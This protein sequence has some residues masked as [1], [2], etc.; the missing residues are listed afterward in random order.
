[1]DLLTS[2][3]ACLGRRLRDGS[4]SAVE[5]TEAAL[6]RIVEWDDVLHAFTN[7]MSVRALAQAK[8]ADAN[9][10][11]GIDLGPLQGI[12]YGVKDIFDVVGE[13][14]TCQSRLGA[15]AVAS[16][17]SD[18]VQRMTAGGAV[19]LGKL[20][21]HEFALYG[22]DASLPQPA[23]RNP[24]NLAHMTGGSSSG[25]GAAIAA[26]F[27]RFAAGSD[28][29]GS[30]RTPAAWCGTVGLKPTY[31]RLSRKGMFPLSDT[32]DHCGLLSATVG[33]CARVF[34]VA[35]GAGLAASDDS[36]DHGY[37]AGLDN[38]VR[39]L[40]VGIAHEFL[41]FA[42]EPVQQEVARVAILLAQ[43]GATIVDVTLPPL[44]LFGA[45]ARLLMLAEGFDV[46]ADALRHHID[47]FGELTARRLALGAVYS[48]RDRARAM[49]VR[50]QLR[51][52]FDAEMRK[53]DVLLSAPALVSAPR[54][55]RP[56]DPFSD[57]APSMTNPFNVTGHPAMSV[58]TGFSDDGM[59][60][61][62]Q[63]I[64]Q[65]HGEGTVFRV[66]TVI[67]QTSGWRLCVPAAMQVPPPEGTRRSH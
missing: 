64:G 23:A 37:F 59:P 60:T 66:G 31:G 65:A 30:S 27:L 15:H 44:R 26:G 45:V 51:A 38:G 17:D 4:I 2:S 8:Q 49:Q 62:V 10:R 16:R 32:L 1:M 54:V 5:L 18:F 21:T 58:P 48:A 9:F 19:L 11:N 61:A 43:A 40:R 20:T 52:R 57:A 14:T 22:P 67:E 12:P 13:A 34:Q 39:G 55:D 47:E 6:T 63:I 53:V 46:H 24:H 25:A 35:A 56:L 7:V 41:Q 42:S 36:E 28:T 3:I 33:D 50:A 29:G